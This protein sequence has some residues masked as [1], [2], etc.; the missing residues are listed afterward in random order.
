MASCF[1]PPRSQTQC[2][3]C[4]LILSR[5]YSSIIST[6][7]FLGSH[8]LLCCYSISFPSFIIFIGCILFLAYASISWLSHLGIF[9]NCFRISSISMSNSFC[10]WLY[11]Y[12]SSFISYMAISVS[13]LLHYST[14]CIL[15]SLIFWG[16]FTSIHLNFVHHS[17]TWLVSISSQK[18]PWLHH[19]NCFHQSLRY[20]TASTILLIFLWKVDFF[21]FHDSSLHLHNK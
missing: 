3:H 11:C 10:C 4:P 16:Y 14:M 18:F 13:P 1:S 21:Q 9:I 2:C 12:N 20:S 5:S 19:Y 8:T 7:N 15:L 6:C 17:R